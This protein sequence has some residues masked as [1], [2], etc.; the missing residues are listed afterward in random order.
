VLCSEAQQLT[1]AL[2]GTVN[3]AA[4]ALQ[5]LA[6]RSGLDVQ[7]ASQALHRD[8]VAN[9]MVPLFINGI[10]GIGSPYWLPRV[11]SRF[12]T[13]FVTD[14]DPAQSADSDTEQLIAVIESIAF[15]L[16]ANRPTEWL[17]DT[18]SGQFMPQAAEALLVRQ[19]RWRLEMA[20]LQQLR[21]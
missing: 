6:E 9:L 2:E 13:D 15:L 10:G 8:Q 17:R 11:E 16:V 19:Q 20:A 7:R 12:V 4:S 18:R 3:G 21:S 1:Y 5:W 14:T